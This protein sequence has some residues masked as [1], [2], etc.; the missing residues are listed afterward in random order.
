MN[1]N[2]KIF[3]ENNEIEWEKAGEGMRRKILGYDKSIMMVLVDFEKGAIGKLHTHPHTQVSCIIKGSFEI[4]IDG[5]KK[6]LKSGDSFFA[7]SNIPHGVIALEP[8]QI[9]DVFTPCREDFLKK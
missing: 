9:L 1:E 8:S 3:I 4:E 5:A 6:V 2:S 7:G